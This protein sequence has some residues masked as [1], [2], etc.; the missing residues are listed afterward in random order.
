MRPSELE[1]AISSVR[2]QGSIVG[3]ILIVDDFSTPAVRQLMV[4]AYSDVSGIKLLFND[5]NLG[6]QRSRNIGIKAASCPAIA[7]MDSDDEW[8][9]GKLLAQCDLL[10]SSGADIVSCGVEFCFPNSPPRSDKKHLRF[11]GNPIH[12][13]LVDG[14]HLQTSTLLCRSLVAKS[15]LFDESVKKFQDWDFVF[16]CFA[17][18][19]VFAMVNTPLVKYHFGASDQ[20]T[21]RPRPNLAR[22]FVSRRRHL[23][24]EEVY[25]L[26]LNRIVARMHIETGDIKEGLSLWFYVFFR[27]GVLDTIGLVKLLRKCLF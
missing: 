10:E 17:V 11:N 15:V 26:S 13:I 23:I 24:G 9:P 12:F 8:L 27:L 18:G 3:E 2:A 7:L 22:E 20:M 21:S 1:R 5:Q 14:G 16:R 19:A 6:A 4:E 25:S